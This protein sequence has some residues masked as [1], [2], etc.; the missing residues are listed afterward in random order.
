MDKTVI[1]THNINRRYMPVA[2]PSAIDKQC[3]TRKE[4]SNKIIKFAGKAKF[5][6]GMESEM[7]SCSRYTEWSLEALQR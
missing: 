6:D 3:K 1:T 4:T 7:E 5:Q 2:E